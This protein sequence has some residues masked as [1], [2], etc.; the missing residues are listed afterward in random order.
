MPNEPTPQDVRTALRRVR[1]FY[2]LGC[3]S[4]KS[5]SGRMQYGMM[6]DEASRFGVSEELLR[7]ARQFADPEQGYALQELR[8][9]LSQCRKAGFALGTTH[10]IRWLTVPKRRRGR[11]ERQTIAEKWNMSRLE[12]EIAKEFGSRRAGGRRRRIPTDSLGILIQLETL[13]DEW[14]RWRENLVREPDESEQKGTEQDLPA[15]VRKR[16]SVVTQEFAALRAL[17]TAELQRQKP[18][19]SGKV[20]AEAHR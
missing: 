8:V 2:D 6:K 10:V 5:N 19:R 4:L 17:V 9:I 18:N 1:S 15:A 11:I 12:A 13:C 7:K 16:L 20:A 14:R 3:K